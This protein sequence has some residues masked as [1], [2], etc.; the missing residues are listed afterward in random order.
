M[1]RLINVNKFISGYRNHCPVST[2]PDPVPASE[3]N[4]V[5]RIIGE[6]VLFRNY[7]GAKKIRIE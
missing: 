2:G 6:A 4:L 3:V 1:V 7:K 5:G